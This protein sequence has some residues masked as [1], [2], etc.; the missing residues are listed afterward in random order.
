MTKNNTTYASTTKPNT[1]YNIVQVPGGNTN[2]NDDMYAY[3]AV[4]LDY[5]G[6]VYSNKYSV[7][8]QTTTKQETIYQ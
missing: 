5:S 8:Y 2:Y 7:V 3:N 1:D 6:T 4:D